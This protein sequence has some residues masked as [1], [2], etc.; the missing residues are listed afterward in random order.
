M[1]CTSLV[2]ISRGLFEC[3]SCTPA[4]GVSRVLGGELML[5]F[6]KFQLMMGNE[7]GPSW[8]GGSGLWELLSDIQ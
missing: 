6:L 3:L 7:V 1:L 8:K 5:R 4:P 2:A